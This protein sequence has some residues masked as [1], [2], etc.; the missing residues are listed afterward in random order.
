MDLSDV[1]ERVNVLEHFPF[2][3]E[4]PNVEAPVISVQFNG[5]T[6]YNFADRNAYDT[7]WTEETHAIAQ[8]VS[9]QI[10]NTT[11]FGGLI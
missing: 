6:D 2:E 10:S 7:R 1:V 9:Y 3:D 8:L 4:Q 5:Y 11:S